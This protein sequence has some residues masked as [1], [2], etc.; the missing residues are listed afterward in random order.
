MIKE[1]SFDDDVYS[2]EGDNFEDE[3][4]DSKI[5]VSRFA[6]I[7][8]EFEATKDD[9]ENYEDDADLDSLGFH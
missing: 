8:D 9:Y 6:K 7:I 5:P 1:L 4:M 3:L 2:T